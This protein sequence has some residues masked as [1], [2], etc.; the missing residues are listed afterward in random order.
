MKILFVEDNADVQEVV[1]RL[2]TLLGHEVIIAN[3]GVE[4]KLAFD[5]YADSI[6]LVITDYRMPN[7]NGVEVLSH[8][9]TKYP[10]MPVIIM[11]GFS[12]EFIHD[13]KIMLAP[14]W[15]LN[16]P[17]PFDIL[18]QVLAMAQLKIKPTNSGEV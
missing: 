1:N 17:V 7:A 2:L 6:D 4:G 12:D 15:C 8:V 11:T 3:D 10:D 16:K 13:P 9:K 18:K 5:Q 14:D